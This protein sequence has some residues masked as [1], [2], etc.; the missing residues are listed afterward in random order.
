MCSV[1]Q[2]PYL[3]LYSLQFGFDLYP[4]GSLHLNDHDDWFHFLNDTSHGSH[5]TAYDNFRCRSYYGDLFL[6]HGSLHDILRDRDHEWYEVADLSPTFLVLI[7]QP[8]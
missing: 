3:D 7:L 5:V 4:S 2:T 8:V 6:L 1:T